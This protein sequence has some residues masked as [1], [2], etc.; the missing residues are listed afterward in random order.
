MNANLSV[1]CNLA[2]SLE[3]KIGEKVMLTCNI[4]IDDHLIN[5]QIGTVTLCLTIK[6]F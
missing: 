1:T 3:L 5:G 6:K 2:H 4:D